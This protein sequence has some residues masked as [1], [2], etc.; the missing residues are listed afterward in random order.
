MEKIRKQLFVYLKNEAC[1]WYVITIY[2]VV[3][4]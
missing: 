1:G 3:Y 4:V 2:D